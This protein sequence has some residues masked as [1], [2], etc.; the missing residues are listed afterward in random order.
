MR[1]LTYRAAQAIQVWIRF[2]VED[3][4]AKCTRDSPRSMRRRRWYGIRSRWWICHA[5]RQVHNVPDIRGGEGMR[6]LDVRL[7]RLSE[8]TFRD[9]RYSDENLPFKPRA[10]SQSFARHR[11]RFV[12]FATSQ[13]ARQPLH[14]PDS[15]LHGLTAATIHHSLFS[16]KEQSG[17]RK[18][19]M[20][21]LF[22]QQ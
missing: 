17:S 2:S 5:R 19:A 22:I 16:R 7:P 4:R 13:P 10:I 12:S 1:I 8:R 9:G 21:F 11:K 15:F 3:F 20:S 18:L 6:C 14:S